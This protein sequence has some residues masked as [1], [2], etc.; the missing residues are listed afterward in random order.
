V[1]VTGGVKG[2]EATNRAEIY[3]IQ[4]LK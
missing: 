3:T 1:L 2:K 4:P